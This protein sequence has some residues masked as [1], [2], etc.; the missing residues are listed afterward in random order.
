MKARRPARFP[1]LRPPL[2]AIARIRLRQ[3][4][5]HIRGVDG[6]FF[7]ATN[8]V[9]FC[10][11]AFQA[12]AASGLCVPMPFEQRKQVRAPV[13]WLRLLIYRLLFE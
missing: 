4:D 9:Q 5:R 12:I 2:N 8:H 10:V 11:F 13:Q 7:D 6:R 3:S 1:D